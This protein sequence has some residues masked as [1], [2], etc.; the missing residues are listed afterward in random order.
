MNLHTVE[1]ATGQKMFLID[2]FL[3]QPILEKVFS[4]F[5]S[6][7]VD[8]EY[9][10]P[11]PPNDPDHIRYRYDGSNPYV[12]EVEQYLSS[13]AIIDTLSVALNKQIRFSVLKFWVDK[14]MLLSAHK[15][16]PN[17]GLSMAQIYITKK[18]YPYLGTTMFQDNKK[19]LFQ[20]PYR[21]N[22]GYMWEKSDK[23]MHGKIFETPEDFNRCSL[24]IFFTE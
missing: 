5:D 21:N 22:F 8:S 23:V 11:D 4:I 12:N 6:F 2:Q 7:S 9:W 19:L 15:E 10:V 3:S 1:L 17:G 13:P 14:K 24:I 16:Q 20:L 18:E